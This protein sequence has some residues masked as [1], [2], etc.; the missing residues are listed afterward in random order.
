MFR[1]T[2]LPLY[3]YRP[4]K[5]QLVVGTHAGKSWDRP[6]DGFKIHKIE[7]EFE[8]LKLPLEVWAKP[9]L[10]CLYRGTCTPLKLAQIEIGWYL[11]DGLDIH[12]LQLCN[13]AR[14]EPWK[15]AN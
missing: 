14:M 1:L 13:C 9:R 7:W 8:R 4:L 3:M 11:M 15:V 6:V 12:F 10:P 2:G 5:R